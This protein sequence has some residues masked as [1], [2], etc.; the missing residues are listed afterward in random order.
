MGEAVRG[1]GSKLYLGTDNSTPLAT[2]N[3]IGH[4]TNI[5][6]FAN[7]YNMID[8]DAELTSEY[9]E[10][11]AGLKKAVTIAVSGNFRGSDNA[12]YTVLKTVHEA[13]S[14]VKFGIVR[15]SGLDGVGGSC[16]VNKLEISEATNEGV[17]KWN[18]ELTTSGARTSFTEPTITYTYTEV[19]P[20]GSESPVSEG[21]FVLSGNFYEAATDTTVDTNKTYYSRSTVS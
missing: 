8:V 9:E 18:A 21:W 2:N 15:P 12:G 1:K 14:L 16:Y 6:A 11:I 13:Q 5:G 20:V 19:E 17:Y 10:K 3:L 7:E 4:V